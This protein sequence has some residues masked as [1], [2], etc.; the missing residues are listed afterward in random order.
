MRRPR[1]LDSAGQAPVDEF[2]GARQSVFRM[3]T[4]IGSGR[5]L[6][7]A[8]DDSGLLAILRD[9]LE[10]EGFRTLTANN[11]VRALEL[12]RDQRP[13]VALVDLHIE[14]TPGLEV[15]EHIA[16]TRPGIHVVLMSGE[17]HGR[18]PSGV[19]FLRKPF[20]VETLLNALGC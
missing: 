14:G 3:H 16:R 11:G 6:L 2:D 17:H 9:V 4:K 10:G 18:P 20:S 13:D 1:R 15:V 8:E 19:T 12:I 7:I 5:L